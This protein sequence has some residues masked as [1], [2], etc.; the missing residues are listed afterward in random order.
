V[1][2]R[3]DLAALGLW[4]VVAAACWM[5]VCG[6]QRPAWAEEAPSESSK[7]SPPKKGNETLIKKPVGKIGVE[8]Q[9]PIQTAPE[10]A[11]PLPKKVIVPAKPVTQFP[12]TSGKPSG[13]GPN[14]PAAAPQP[15]PVAPI[16]PELL[17][18]ENLR[19]APPVQPNRVET[20]AP[21]RVAPGQPMYIAGGPEFGEFVVLLGSLKCLDT[22]D[23]GPIEIG[24][25]DL[26]VGFGVLAFYNDGTYK[27]FGDFLDAEALT[28]RRGGTVSEG[29]EGGPYVSHPV[30]AHNE[31][32]PSGAW[33]E[34][35]VAGK[36]I[37]SLHVAVVMLEYD[38]RASR[39][40]PSIPFGPHP[41][42][43]MTRGLDYTDWNRVRRYLNPNPLAAAT[44][45]YTGRVV[46]LFGREMQRIATVLSNSHGSDPIGLAEWRF[47]HEVTGSEPN[48]IWH[49]IYAAL[50]FGAVVPE[51][52]TLVDHQNRLRKL[53]VHS[54]PAD[55]DRNPF[56]WDPTGYLAYK[57]L[58]GGYGDN[59][60]YDGELWFVIAPGPVVD[61]W[62]GGAF[63]PIGD[64]LPAPR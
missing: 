63:R 20:S 58:F 24:G 22:T 64:A 17:R 43:A 10:K 9:G 13:A 26:R 6:A 31:R 51:H 16:P 30:V 45:V 8:V 55:L 62:G 28:G 57:R 14:A 38:P 32:H 42:N 52:N 61:Q 40:H 3:K 18:T 44:E 19:P 35:G 29:W 59:S 21:A 33:F 54:R 23:G 53:F 60:H 25:D 49:L 27:V 5:M 48:G 36:R 12:I 2:P 7:S 50:Q 47:V 15:R 1:N 4:L 39:D 37:E 11:N 41:G 46:T 34:A 56:R